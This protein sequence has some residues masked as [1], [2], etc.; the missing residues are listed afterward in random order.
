MLYRLC[1]ALL[2]FALIT[3]C[4]S[5]APTETPASENSTPLFSQRNAAADGIDFVNTLSEHP[6]PNRNLLL[7][8]YFSNGGGIAVGDLNGDQQEDLY[9]SGNMSYNKLYLNRGNWRFED[10][11]TSAGVGGRKNTWKTGVTIADVNGDGRLDI[12]ASYSGDLPLDRRVDQLLINMGNDAQGIPQFEDQTVAYGLAN[13]HSSNQGYFFDYDRDGDLDLFL[14]THN[15]KNVRRLDSE[16][17]R[18]EMQRDNPVTGVRLYAQNN[19]RFTDVT[20]AAGLSSSSLTY[21]LGAGI[22]DINQDGWPDFYV[23]NDYNAPD[24]LYI[25]RGDGTFEDELATRIRHTSHAS[26]GIDIADINNDGLVEVFV[27][28]MLAEEN[29]RQKTQ[30][31]PN[32]RRLFNLMVESGF[33]HQYLRNTLQLN[34]GDGTFSEVGMLAGVAQTDWS[35]TPLL[36]DFDSDGK[37]DLFVTNGYLYDTLDQDFLAFKNSYIA[38]KQQNL[39]PNDIGYLMG[40]VPTSPMY[41]YAFRNKDGLQFENVSADWGLRVPQ[42]SAGAVYADLDNDGDLDLVLNN[43]NEPAAVF[44]NHAVDQRQQNYLKIELQ[45]TAGNTEGLGSRVSLFV[46]GEEQ[47]VEQ[48]PSRGYL[49]SVTRH[50]HFGLGSRATVD[51]LHVIWPDGRL[52]KRES[53]EANQLLVLA[54]AEASGQYQPVSPV[55]PAFSP[56]ATPIVFEHQTDPQ[57]DDF[58]RQPL[59]DHPQSESGPPLATAD[60]NGDGRTDVFAGGGVGQAG[61][62]Y[63]GTTRGSMGRGNAS[64]FMPAA[65][66]NDTKAHFF[67]ANNDDAPDLYVAS[68]GYHLFDEADA[69]L[70]DRLY[71]NTGSG[72]LV[73]TALPEMLTSTGAVASGDINGDGLADLFVGGGV[74]PGKYPEIPLSR[75]LINGGDGQFEEVVRVRMGM[76]RDAVLRDLDQDGAPELVVAGHWMPL[77]VYRFSQ[78]ELVDV[79]S[80]FFDEPLAGLW[81]T[82]HVEDLNGDGHVDLVAGNLGLNTQLAATREQPAS[83]YYAD[84]N[85]DGA[86]DPILDFYVQGTPY[87]FIMLDELRLQLPDVAGQFLSFSQFANV[88]TVDLFGTERLGM[89]TRLEANHMATTLL[90]GTP[91]GIFKQTPL[92]LAVQV[93]PVFAILSLDY[94]G[95]GATDLLMA[96]NTTDG[97][98]RLG[99]Y[100]A[101]YGVLLQGDG[102]G[103]FTYVTQESAGFAVRGAVRSLVAL[104]GTILFGIHGHGVRAY[105]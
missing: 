61:R 94:N 39:T 26:M 17:A 99:R 91:E 50:L 71:L 100:D 62:L 101:N 79:T 97:Q 45:G 22:S 6:S 93:A 18:R 49:S 88:Q 55:K 16:D 78:N 7:F 2:G 10:V 68:G 82:V 3:G 70:Q 19:G 63:L 73:A 9:F 42:R 32:D 33:H 35:W 64:P 40:V 103:G 58:S 44:E 47:H 53:V 28:D 4:T 23:G 30:F 59:L 43:I 60:V 13:P 75:V 96:G 95:D 81:N 37:K 24:F 72:V 66:S 98:M 29:R 102:S 25:N 52:L 15:V 87:P 31:M 57:R 46:D 1:L 41:N 21:G 11:T 20:R 51:S 80:D 48:M 69:T 8:E 38:S 65:G 5:D 105:R 12:Y 34:N 67:D 92:P 85:N 89:A 76:V 27:L 86:V 14:L 36:A 56:I 104:D 90:L 74:V 84:F 77:S 54:Q 83:L